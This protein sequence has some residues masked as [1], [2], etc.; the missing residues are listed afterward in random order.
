MKDK[1][2]WLLENLHLIISLII[3]VPTAIIYGAAPFSL[4]PQHLDIQVMTND[5]S[6]LLRAIMFLYL[7]VSF[8]WFL[9]ILKTKYWKLATQLNILFMLTL[10]MG[11][12]LSMVID[13]LPTGGYIFAVIAELI[14]GFYSIY[15]LRKYRME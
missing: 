7:G 15:Q 12:I 11:R 4:L 10:A 3:V 2:N 8:I 13:G 14:L 9:G 5:L 6:N 1:L